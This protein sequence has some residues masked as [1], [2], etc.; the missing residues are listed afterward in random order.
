MTGIKSY[1]ETMKAVFI[2]KPGGKLIIKEVN[3]PKPG[4]GEVLIKMAAAPVNPSDIAKIRDAHTDNDLATYIPGLEGS[5]TVVAAGNGFLPHL[6]TGKRIA[7]SSVHN[8]SG[9]WAEYMV[10]S[11]VKCFPLGRNIT[12]EQGSMSLVNPL[13]ALAF[14]EIIRK[15]GHKAIINN[16]SASAL[17]RMV[18][19]LCKKQNI[20]VINIVRNRRQYEML[21]ALGSEHVLDNSDPD[22]IKNIGR[23]SKQLNATILFDSV[24]S[25]QLEQIIDVLPS[26]S[27]VIIYGNLSGEPLI[28]INPRRL[29]DN[30]IKI[31]GF[32]LGQQAKENGIL[33]NVINLIKVRS[34]MKSDLKIKIHRRFH[35]ENAQEAVDTYLSNMSGGKVI[36]VPGEF[37]HT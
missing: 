19:M 1:P 15:Y 10:T 18:E 32:Y 2:E 13:T 21:I 9:T 14:L 5:G 28:M 33:K 34:L 27:S 23:L 11:A 8:S 20:P 24:C 31:S 3:T 17:G 12:D 25:L 7:C 36:L 30:N 26:D 35:L 22:F 6:L 16:A 29:I 37:H 4:P